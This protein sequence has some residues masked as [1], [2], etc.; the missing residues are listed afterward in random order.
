MRLLQ[1]FQSQMCAPLSV[2]LVTSVCVIG[3]HQCS[4][5]VVRYGLES[6]NQLE[7]T[8]KPYAADFFARFE[9]LTRFGLAIS[10]DNQECYFAVALNDEGRFREEIRFT[11]RNE[12]GGWTNPQALLPAEKKFKYVDPHFSPDRKRLFFIY[13]KPTQ[14]ENAKRRRQA[15]DI[16][17]IERKGPGWGA[18]VNLGAPISTDDAEEYFVS[19]TSKGTIFFGSNRRDRKNFDLYSARLRSDGSYEEPQPLPGRVNTNKYEA[20]VF[21]APDE[22][23][24]IF[25]SSGRA[26]GLGQGDLYVSFKEAS[27]DW[28]AAVNLGDRVNSDQ[29]EFAPSVSADQKALFF[30][31]GGVLHW[32][33][34]AV[35]EELRP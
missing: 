5:Q 11:R 29:Q 23:Y 28:S 27:G 4:A 24:V 3:S 31:R 1:W 8:A 20:D 33:S 35:I 12:K 7:K 21:V 18:P 34:T 2:L 32:V 26:D 15:F 17:Y 14:S 30:S 22:S 13:T 10:D 9:K 16:W 25:S 19:L 6:G